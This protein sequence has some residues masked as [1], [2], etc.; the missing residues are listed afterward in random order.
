M[1]KM[2]VQIK[3]IQTR[4]YTIR[5]VKVMLDRDLAE[6][7]QVEIKIFNQAVKRNAK[8]FPSDFRFQLTKDEWESLRSQYVTSKR[9]RGGI[10]YLPYAFS[11][12]GA[13]MLSSVL[14][15]NLA[16]EINI[17]IMRAFVELR[18]I[19]AAQPEYELLKQTIKKIEAQMLVENTLTSNKMSQLSREVNRLSEVF[20][21]FQDAHIM[22]KRPENGIKEG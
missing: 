9:G 7:Y 18:N 20:D 12:Q 15:S 4:I 19:I 2:P 1:S 10:R 8:R 13:T 21:N 14:N 17:R 11:E 22:L 5:G 16:I 6:L 3:E